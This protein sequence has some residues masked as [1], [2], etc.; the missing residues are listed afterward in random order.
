MAHTW[1]EPAPSK[2]GYRSSTDEWFDVAQLLKQN[3]NRSMNFGK[4]KI[5]RA[6]A[7]NSGRLKA[8][9]E[10]GFEAT[11]RNIDRSTGHGTLFIRYTGD[12]S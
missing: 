4:Q 3:P 2:R 5:W 9:R 11:M 1:E 12:K 7:I 8:F 10:P 6:T